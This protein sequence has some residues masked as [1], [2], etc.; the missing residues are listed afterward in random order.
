MTILLPSVKNAAADRPAANHSN[1]YPLHKIG[2]QIA[3]KT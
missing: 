2:E 3:D 1:A